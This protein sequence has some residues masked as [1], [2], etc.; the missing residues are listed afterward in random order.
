MLIILTS[1]YFDCN[2]VLNFAHGSK[3]RKAYQHK[4]KIRILNLI[5]ILK[6]FKRSPLIIPSL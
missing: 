1:L 3:V 2:I 4:K 6:E 5:A